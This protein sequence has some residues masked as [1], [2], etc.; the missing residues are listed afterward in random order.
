MD[1]KT[2]DFPLLTNPF[3]ENP[4]ITPIF[5]QL[6]TALLGLVKSIQKAAL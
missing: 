5:F 3:S 1:M 2:V 6:C 4:L